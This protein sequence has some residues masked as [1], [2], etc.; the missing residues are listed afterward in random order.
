MVGSY[1]QRK[2]GG[3]RSTVLIRNSEPIQQFR[4]KIVG[5][6]ASPKHPPHQ[7]RRWKGV[8]VNNYG[9]GAD[10][11]RPAALPAPTGPVPGWVTILQAITNEARKE[12][13]R[14]EWR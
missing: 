4:D 3:Q 6:S 5:Q 14:H 1:T 9:Q 11:R 8:E 13:E 12:S 7:P 2:S 10:V